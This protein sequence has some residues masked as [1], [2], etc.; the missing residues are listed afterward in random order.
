MTD[1]HNV[2]G[3]G[4]QSHLEVS[5]PSRR[6]RQQSRTASPRLYQSKARL[7]ACL[8]ARGRK[9]N[10][11]PRIHKVA[12]QERFVRWEDPCWGYM[13]ESVCLSFL[14]AGYSYLFQRQQSELEQL[15]SEPVL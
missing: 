5:I 2:K 6:C 3:K 9:A 12:R 4:L 13:V 14:V 1:L 11:K 7:T 10:R 8:Q 15:A